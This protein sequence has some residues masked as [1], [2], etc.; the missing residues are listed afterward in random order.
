MP[1]VSTV[2]HD[3]ALTNVA[4]AYK[5]ASYIAGGIA[6][7]VIVRRQSNK[8]FTY[9]PD[10]EALRS[11]VDHRAPGAEANEVHFDL[12]SDSYFCDDHALESVIPDEERENS[13]T[14]LQPEVD[15]TEFLADKI[16]LNEEI[17]LAAIL[18]D[19]T[20]IPATDL[21]NANDRWDQDT[22][23]PAAD[24]EDARSAIV[25]ATQTMPNVLVL[26]FD[27]YKKVRNN[28]KV[29]ERVKYS[30]LGVVG[31]EELAQLFDVE[32]VLVPRAVRNTAAAGQPA[33]LETIWGKD[34]LLL[35]VP[36]RAGLKVIAPVLTFVWSQA[37]GG[38]RGTSGAR[39]HRN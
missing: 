33:V 3:V 32:R 10:R 39:Q 13:D 18:R 35:H 12:S 17:G 1:D 6:P 37:P 24:I 4:I 7:E 28:P 34:A 8:Y 5:N 38:L 30:R 16:L 22:V 21:A 26:P 23:D 11:T 36:P 29:T 14:P 2:H 19:D 20:V 27:V 15:R 9:D 31:P 25:A